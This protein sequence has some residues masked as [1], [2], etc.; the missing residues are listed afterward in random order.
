[1]AQ[2]IMPTG[3]ERHFDPGEMLVSKTDMKGR[4]TYCNQLFRTIAGY[5]NKELLGQPHS[6]VRH[7]D[8]P[9]AVF[10]HL[11]TALE[12]RREVFAYVKN[13]ASN[14][15]HYWVFAHVTP[16]LNGSGQVIGYHSARRAPERS[17]LSD[18]IEPL[19]R[20]LRAIENGEDN[21]KVGLQKSTNHLADIL[22]EK[23]TTYDQFILT[24]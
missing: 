16:S 20:D 19:Y 15:D 8:M 5:S 4:I 13:M 11:W 10:K 6:C 7:P 21:R 2:R 17:I 12:A 3:L 1:M 22:E 14:G 23:R 24:L 18:V 9:R